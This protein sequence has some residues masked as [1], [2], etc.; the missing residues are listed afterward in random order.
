MSRNHMILG[1]VAALLASAHYGA[2]VQKDAPSPEDTIKQLTEQLTSLTAAYE[3]KSAEMNQQF[4]DLSTHFSGVKTD[5]GELKAKVEEQTAKYA[6]MTAETQQLKAALDMVKKELDSPQFGSK[7]DKDDLI[8]KGQIELQRSIHINQHGNSKGFVEQKEKFIDPAAYKSA[9]YKLLDVGIESKATIV[10]RFTEAERKAFDM[11]GMDT[12]FFSPQMLG[13]EIDCNI[14]CAELL[15]LYNSVSVSRT[16]FMYPR[17]RSYADIGKYTCDASCSA[18]F[19]PEG[20]VQYLQ[21]ETYDFRG[22]F[23][24]QK[25]VLQEANYDLLDFMFRSAARSHRINRNAASIVGDGMNQ[26]LG[27]L[28]ADLF[29][30]RETAALGFNHQDFRRFLS[31]APVEYGP[32]VAT[33]HQN[34]FGYLASAVDANG[35]FIFG[36]G[37]MTFSPDD[38]T[39]R[40][41][42]SN[43]LPD[44]TANNTLGGETP[45]VAGS[46]IAAAGNWNLAYYT[47]EKRPMW[48]EQHVGSTTAWCVAYQF[49]A[50]DGGFVACPEAARILQVG[51]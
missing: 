1:S 29:Q 49:G 22:L 41:R 24:F 20:N 37:E 38:T 3:T 16:K 28:E 2:I 19:G 51:A 18:E 30:K 5:N 31:S 13:I 50:E 43:C 45:F 47:V 6:E 42:I 14:E 35:R 33:M 32:V 4:K 26:P 7:G 8:T 12:A 11:S 23:C 40:L 25:K 21:G 15:S 36:D 10:S 34:V 9:A 46:F 17:V 48:I 44:P 39:A 27:W